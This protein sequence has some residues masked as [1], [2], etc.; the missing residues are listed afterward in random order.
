MAIETKE[1]TFEQEIEYSLLDHGGY[2]KGNPH[3][4]NREFAIDT[5]QLFRFLQDS[6]PVEWEK[7]CRKHG[8]NVET[9]FLKKLYRDLD[10]YGTLYV[11]R[12]G[13]VD[14]PAKLSLCYFKPASGM[15]QTS[16][17]LYEK[18]ILSITRQVHYSLKNENSIDVVLF[19]NGLPVATV[20]LK[21]PITGQT[22][23]NAKRQ[24]MK[25]RDPRELLLSFKARCLVHFAVD[26]EEVWMT[27][28]LNG[29]NTYFLPFNKGNNGG[30][31][32]PVGNSTYRTSYLWEEVLQKD[33]LLDIVQRF[34]HLQ[35]DKKNPKKSVMIFPRYHQLDVV[36]KL[37]ADVYANGTGHNYLIQH[38]AGS[39]KSNSISWL[40]HHLSNL[41]D[42][43]DK[44]VF[45][46]IIVITDRLVLDIKNVGGLPCSYVFM[47]LFADVLDHL[48]WKTGFRIDG[49][50]MS[51]YNI[52]AVAM[53]GV[54]TGVFN[55]WLAG[56][57]YVAPEMVDGVTQAVSQSA[58]VQ[59]IIIF[60]FVGLE[61]FTGIILTVLLIFLSVEKNIGKKQAEIKSRREKGEGGQKA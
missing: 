19:I 13:V 52:I 23:E 7:L 17:A 26:T 4:Y 5:K 9:G 47:A 12:H 22:V 45:N 25:D 21:N 2:I 8:E 57:G 20:E 58:S 35:E 36:R 50:A 31:G 30:K 32:N 60:G 54:C 53:V 59:N 28:K 42:K 49:I 3:D 33:S 11:L 46:S 39:G 24:Y 1:I 10:T 55:G 15:N 18:N 43:N 27:T 61:V 40:A 51:V 29:L 56:A 41:H 48:E 34:I 44:V 16:Q 6:Q 14:A 37:V 38:S